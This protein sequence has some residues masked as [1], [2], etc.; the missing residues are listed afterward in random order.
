MSK[1]PNLR[2]TTVLVHVINPFDVK[3]ETLKIKEKELP[4]KISEIVGGFFSTAGSF[5]QSGDTLYVKDNGA[6]DP[7]MA[8]FMFTVPHYPQ[9]LFGKGVVVATTI[10]GDKLDAVTDWDWLL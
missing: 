9:P 1:Y 2:P 3:I 5:D 10:Y 7:A 8:D 6:N 4:D